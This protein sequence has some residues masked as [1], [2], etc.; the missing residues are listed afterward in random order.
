[1]TKSRV[2]L[3]LLLSFIAG[4]AIRSFV[5]V[6]LDVIAAGFWISAAA[7]AVGILRKNKFIIIYSF[8]FL[9]FWGGVLRFSQAARPPDLSSL[10][11]R[12]LEVKGIVAEN[13]ELSSRTQRLVLRLEEIEGK[14]LDNPLRVLVTTD[15]YPR[16]R[17]GN[18]LAVQGVLEEPQ[19]FSAD[20]DY[21]A[22]LAKDNIYSIFFF[23]KVQKIGEGKG[24]KLKLVLFK[25]KKAFEEKIEAAFPE[26]HAAFL[27]GLLLGE[28][29]SLPRGLT[30][31]F[32]RTGVT[33]I[34]ALSGYNITLVADFFVRTL[35]ALS[36]PFRFAFWIAVLGIT[37]F[38]LLT[39]ASASITRAGIMGVLVLL[40]QREGRLYSIRNALA[41][42]GAIMV[43]Y[44]PKILRFDAAFQLSFLATLGLIYLSPRVEKFIDRTRAQIYLKRGLLVFPKDPLQE[45]YSLLPFRK[46]FVETISAQLAV[47]PLLIWL[48][49]RVSLVSPLS[50][51]LVIIA[52]PYSMA[53]GFAAGV[54]GF[55]WEPLSQVL[56]WIGWIFLEYKIRIIEFFA[57]VPVASLKLPA[58]SAGL[59]VLLYILAAWRVW[60]SSSGILR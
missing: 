31:D 39:G 32:N 17:L 21:R 40:A 59:L 60:K 4:V 7:I 37:F 30:E 44:N 11:G 5:A 14:E 16:Y 49:G 3:W 19:N 23:P 51:L 6:P 13:P 52:V 24:S 36:I 43:F 35:L 46:I 45:R 12:E 33:H 8:I 42:A 53:L 41:F 38:V 54:A 55:I 50:N 29:G 15:L 1:M 22:Y 10:Y 2:F 56:G 20:F 25:I 58:W 48:F 18:E 9:T 28:R 57:A 26:P 34:I 47:L 27:K